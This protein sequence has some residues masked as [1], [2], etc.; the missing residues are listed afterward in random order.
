MWRL[1]EWGQYV[2]YYPLKFVFSV[3]VLVFWAI[4]TVIMA[5]YVSVEKHTRRFR[6]VLRRQK[7]KAPNP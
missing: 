1:Y 7:K 5:A 2:L 3:V 6:R 4:S